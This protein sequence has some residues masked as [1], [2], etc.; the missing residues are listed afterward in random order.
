MKV[1]KE[2]WTGVQDGS[3]HST[4]VTT[5][6]GKLVQIASVMETDTVLKKEDFTDLTDRSCERRG[7]NTEAIDKIKTSSN[8]ICI[9]HDSA[10]KKYDV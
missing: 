8:K 7:W 9:R 10:K 1:V 2:H 3:K 4:E 5:S 6:R